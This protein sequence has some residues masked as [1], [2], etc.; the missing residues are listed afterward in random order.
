MRIR[1]SRMLSR[2]RHALVILAGLTALVL[3]VRHLGV[4]TIGGLIRQVGWSFWLI[5][6][7]YAA[8]TALRGVALWQ[9][10]PPGAIPLL[11]V[12][13]IRFGAEGIE[14]LTLTGP[15]L[16][17]P[18]KGWL[19]HRRGV[20]GP[21]AF[22]AVAAEYLLYNVTA[23]WMGAGALAVLLSRD[24]L[25]RALIGPAH[26]LIAIVAALT[27]GC[28]IAGVTG[29]GLLVPTLGAIAR[30][31]APRR[32]AALVARVAPVEG[33]LVSVLHDDPRRLAALLAV[34]AAGHALLAIE[35]MVTLHALG[36]HA[37]PGAAFV[38]EGGVKWIGTLFFFVPGQLGVSEGMYALLLPMVALPAAAGVTIGL[39][40]RGRSLLV[41]TL[42]FLLVAAP[43]RP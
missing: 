22:G 10:L 12:I 26:I 41:G 21:E 11:D 1:V 42:G 28:V 30:R 33:V 24:A 3:I 14:M 37:G 25:P 13:G 32:A 43:S 4:A 18:A 31:A 8:H 2:A 35:I 29:R 39:V 19:L 5:A 38:I 40:R 16:A 17:E 9:T 20:A 34:E 36:L 6:A 27:I 7:I 15:F 23:G